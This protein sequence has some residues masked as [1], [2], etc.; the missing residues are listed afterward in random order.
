MNTIRF[1]LKNA[2][3]VALPQSFLPA[4]LALCMA[5]RWE[6]FSLVPALAAV[7][8]V[9]AGHLSVNLFD[10]YFDY[11]VRKPDHRDR[12]QHRGIRARILKCAYLTSGDAT[13]GQLLAAC[14]AFG[15]V[16]LA[17]GFIVYLYRG[18]VILLLAAV[19]AVLGLFYSAPPLRLS[20]HGLGEALVGFMFGPLSM[21][22]I[23]F[24]SC[25]ALDSSVLFVS[26]PVGLLVANIVYTHAIMDCEPDKEVG[27]MTL[28]VLLKTKRRMLSCL[29]LLLVAAF[30]GIVSGVASGTLSPC[31]LLALLTLPMAAELFY[32]MIE[33]VRHPQRNFTLPRFRI[34]PVG[35][36]QRQRIRAAGIDWFMIRWLLAR[37]LLAFFCILLTVASLLSDRCI[38]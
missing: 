20:Y 32:L 21:S 11:R 36:R 2:R 35:D 23:F 8:G 3:S 29:L 15:A 38:L 4:C 19:T 12:M 13:P 26:V 28:A 30:A 14:C 22:G 5:S 33:F 7:A 16:A 17:A 9:T 24:A 10:D 34:G 27:K 37:N 18:N 31:Y 25:G 1:W 6:G